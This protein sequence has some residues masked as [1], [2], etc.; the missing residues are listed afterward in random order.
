M[1]F[2]LFLLGPLGWL[3]AF[4]ASSK[5]QWV[6]EYYSEGI[7]RFIISL[8]SIASAQAAF[9]IAEILVFIILIV[10]I[11]MFAYAVLNILRGKTYLILREV[12][13]LTL[14]FSV[15]YFLFVFLWGLN[16]Y[17]QPFNEIAGLEI[18]QGSEEEVI[19]LSKEL[20]QEANFL[21]KDLSENENGIMSLGKE[22]LDIL[23]EASEG[24]AGAAVKYK[25]LDGEYGQAKPV[26]FSKVLSYMGIT[27]VY[28]PFTGEANI[29]RDIPDSMIPSTACHEMA[30]QRGFAKEDEANYIAYL[31]CMANQDQRYQYSGIILAL[32]Y[33]MNALNEQNPGMASQLRNQYCPGLNRDLTELTEYWQKHEG[34]ME[35]W[36]TKM[37]DKY[38]KSNRQQEGVISYGKVVDLLLAERRIDKTNF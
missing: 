7:Y 21:R 3:A 1:K 14:L 4:S 6:E 25:Q 5:S 13:L 8:L 30:H 11:G 16:Y 35:R 18:K 9:S 33:S 10:V 32:S 26:Y 29:N 19:A 34:I 2:I 38:L 27:G 22:K 36:S 23:T 31:A 12:K 20:I 24:F 28:F 37:N 15:G 17:R